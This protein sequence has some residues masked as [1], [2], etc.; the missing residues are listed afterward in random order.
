MPYSKDITKCL[1]FRKFGINFSNFK[2]SNFISV[3]MNK[4]PCVPKYHFQFFT[5]ALLIWAVSPHPLLIIIFHLL[6]FFL[7][8]FLFQEET[9]PYAFFVEDSEITDT[10]EKALS[11][12]DIHDTE[13][14]VD[15]VYQPL[16]VFRVRAV[17]R[18]TS[19]LVGHSEACFICIFQ[20][21]WKVSCARNLSYFSD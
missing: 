14:V 21:W 20:S 17:T 7:F 13:Q 3:Y 5:W 9:T 16:A 2:I 18:C 11:K 6:S 4:Y 15:I 8:F 19:T 1:Y 12:R 10:V